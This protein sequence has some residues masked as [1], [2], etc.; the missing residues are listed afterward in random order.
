MEGPPDTSRR[1]RCHG[2]DIGDEGIP[3]APSENRGCEAF[4]ASLSLVRYVLLA[5][6][7][8]VAKKTR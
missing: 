1:R 4:F 7:A 5:F 6:D 3:F 8:F 2:T